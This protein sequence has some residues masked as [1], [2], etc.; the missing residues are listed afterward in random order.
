MS[1]LLYEDFTPHSAGE[2]EKKNRG[3]VGGRFERISDKRRLEREKGEGLKEQEW[4][5]FVCL[6][7]REREVI[8]L[9]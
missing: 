9:C 8:T 5:V 2:W 6:R 1:E 4:F 3:E 7:H